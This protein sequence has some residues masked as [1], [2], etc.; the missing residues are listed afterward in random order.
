M[1]TFFFTTGRKYFYIKYKNMNFTE[2][3]EALQNLIP[4]FKITQMSI[5]NVL[6]LSRQTMN[7]RIK[8]DTEVTVSELKAIENS[9]NVSLYKSGRY[10]GERQNDITVDEKASQFGKRLSALQNKHNFLDKEMAKLLDITEK[11]Y[12]ALVVG[13]KQ[14]TFDI[15]NRI[16][17][18]FK[19]SIDYLLYGD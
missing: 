18:N 1:S 8:F 14:P 10:S 9:F 3:Q 11:T 4:N 2:L 13:D 6:H 17:Q 15:L 19:V 16:K 7:K 5:A 12:I